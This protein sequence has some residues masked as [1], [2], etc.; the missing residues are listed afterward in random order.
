MKLLKDLIACN[1]FE[2][3][4]TRI[5]KVIGDF[6][7]SNTGG[8]V[9]EQSVADKKSN[10]IVCF[11]APRLVINCHMDT[12]VPSG[13]WDH[14]P[15]QLHQE[16][17]RLYGLG[18]ADTKGNLYMVLKAAEASNPKDLMLLF[19]IDEEAGSKTGVEYFLAAGHGKNLK[20]AIVCEP[21]ALQF[22][23][24][25]KGAYSFYV[26]HR[27]E[28]G[29]SSI[30]GESAVVE[31]AKD[32]LALDAQGFNIGKVSCA[33]ASNILAENCRFKASLRTYEDP[34]TAN[35]RIRKLS[36]RGIILSSFIGRPL[37]N[38]HPHIRTAE[39]ELDFWTEA[40]LFQDAGI[41]A[42]V[43][44]AGHIRQAHRMNE[45]VEL[46]QLIDGQRIIEKI[47]GEEK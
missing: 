38:D 12:V 39:A 9:V 43:F 47:I 34:E 20:K 21:T 11:G 18:T 14:P 42:V 32:I 30:K 35:E 15:L 5:L 25:H 24:R 16:N 19:S 41:N 29:H 46:Q 37:V 2:G 23:K 26:E 31:A 4:Y 8:R 1:T 45:Y 27:A 6:V 17:G 36:R 10:L 40:P 13:E 28:G 3:D 44:G 22:A 33:S 7:Q